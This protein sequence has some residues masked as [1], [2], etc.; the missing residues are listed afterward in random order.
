[1]CSWRFIHASPPCCGAKCGALE[2]VSISL[3]GLRGGTQRWTE[4]SV[5]RARWRIHFRLV[6]V[7]CRARTGETLCTERRE[8]KSRGPDV[9]DMGVMLTGRRTYDIT[10]GWNGTHPVN[11]IPVV[12]LT[13]RMSAL[14]SEF[15]AW[16]PVQSLRPGVEEAARA[17]CSAAQLGAYRSASSYFASASCK[18][19]RLTSTSPHAFSGSAQCGAR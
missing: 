17:A 6:R 14:A 7:L 15:S 19:P 10:N 9:R 11:A 3:D 5:R 12:I 4:A 13:Q 16:P 2:P 1:M 18:C 8:S